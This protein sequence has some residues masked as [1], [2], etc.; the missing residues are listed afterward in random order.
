[1]KTI[2]ALLPT[3]LFLAPA[4]AS[5]KVAVLDVRKAVLS[6]QDGKTAAGKLRQ[7]F[8]PDEERLQ[9]LQIEIQDLRSQLS[10]GAARTA[11]ET[12]ALRTRLAAL[13][14]RHRREEEDSRARLEREQSRVLRELAGRLL[15]VVETYAKQKHFE[16]ILDES[17][18]KT[19]IYWRA[20]NVDI[21]E[22]VIKRYD[23]AARK[24]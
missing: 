16:A 11:E 24:K 6:T 3:I 20:S 1:M 2:V 12:A 23:Q 5:P 13:T 4:Q 14:V 19:P 8:A 22:E 9:K 7:E 10:K 18:P 21:T 15:E 17:D